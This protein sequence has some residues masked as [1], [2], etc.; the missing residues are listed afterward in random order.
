MMNLVRKSCDIPKW[1]GTEK[2]KEIGESLFEELYSCFQQ[3]PELS[4][5]YM[6]VIGRVFRVMTSY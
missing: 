5:V 2:E 1:I 3:R 6:K 4:K